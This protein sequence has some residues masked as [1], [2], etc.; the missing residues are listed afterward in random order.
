[1]NAAAPELSGGDGAHEGDG[2]VEDGVDLVVVA[3]FEEV[4]GAAIVSAVP[5]WS[6]NGGAPARTCDVGLA[7]RA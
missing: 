1:V 4:L 6:R 7:A 2:A 5:C 3:A